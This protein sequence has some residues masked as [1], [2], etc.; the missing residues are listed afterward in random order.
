MEIIISILIAIVMILAAFI[1]GRATRLEEIEKLFKAF[2]RREEELL[3]D[4]SGY[5]EDYINGFREIKNLLMKAKE[6]E[7][8]RKLL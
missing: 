5:S 4:E 2:D 1:T 3:S 6:K 7:K 8:H